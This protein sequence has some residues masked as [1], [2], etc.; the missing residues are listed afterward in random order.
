MPQEKFHYKSLEEVKQRAAELGVD[1][2]LQPTPT[3]WR[4]R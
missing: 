4:S 3:R 1:L 2:P